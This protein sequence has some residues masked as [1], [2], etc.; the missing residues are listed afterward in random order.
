MKILITG[1]PIIGLAKG[2]QKVFPT[3]DFISRK[4]DH[5][6]TNLKTIDEIALKS[7]EYDVVINNIKLSR[8]SQTQLLSS[9]STEWIK[10]NKKGKI[11]NIGSV[12]DR[13][14]RSISSYSYSS[15]KNSLKHLSRQLHYCYANKQLPFSSSYIAFGH[16]D[17]QFGQAYKND[18]IK[19]MSIDQC[20]S[21]VLWIIENP[22]AV[23]ELR[24]EPVQ[25]I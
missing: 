1:N 22:L 7:L 18:N 20:A 12:A 6:L 4:T 23:E 2:L 24:I 21:I 15:E 25:E 3:A 8:F 16:I 17:T 14:I 11:I 13:F 5:D 9:I 19:K 10:H